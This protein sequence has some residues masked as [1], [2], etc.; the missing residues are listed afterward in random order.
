MYQHLESTTQ[1]FGLGLQ[2]FMKR[3]T[4][5]MSMSYS[6]YWTM[7]AKDRWQTK[8]GQS[9]DTFFWVFF[10]TLP[11]KIRAQS[12]GLE[13]MY[14]IFLSHRI[15]TTDTMAEGVL[16]ELIHAKTRNGKHGKVFKKWVIKL[17]LDP[18]FHCPNA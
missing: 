15:K 1:V 9:D 10:R 7:W 3:K 4:R 5:R 17:G 12:V 14:F 6:E 11:S 16:H 8:L 18:Y 13:N 2:R